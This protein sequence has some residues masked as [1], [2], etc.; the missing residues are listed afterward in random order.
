[1]SHLDNY[2]EKELQEAMDY[3]KQA[4]TSYEAIRAIQRAM[5]LGQPIEVSFRT[6]GHA[7]TALCPSKAGEKLLAKLEMQ[8]SNRVANLEKQE[9]YWCQEVAAQEQH[10]TLM[11]RLKDNP[12]ISLAEFW[13]RE[14]EEQQAKHASRVYSLKNQQTGS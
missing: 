2:A 7:V 1:M 11:T 8:A 12:T 3:L 6:A 13:N 5:D 9:V 4:R 14:N 10:R